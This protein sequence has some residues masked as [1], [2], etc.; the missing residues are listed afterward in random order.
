MVIKDAKKYNA[1][2]AVQKKNKIKRA[3][4]NEPVVIID[5]DALPTKTKG[6]KKK[7]SVEENNSYLKKKKKKKLDCKLNNAACI[8]FPIIMQSN[9]DSESIKETE[10]QPKVLKKKRKRRL[11]CEQESIPSQGQ[12]TESQEV[13]VLAGKKRKRH[14]PDTCGGD[15]E[16]NTKRKKKK[17]HKLAC[18]LILSQAEDDYSETDLSAT[19]KT[20]SHEMRL[21]DRKRTLVQNAVS[22]GQSRIIC[23]IISVDHRGTSSRILKKGTADPICELQEENYCKQDQKDIARMLKK[24]REVAEP[25]KK[26]SKKKLKK[27]EVDFLLTSVGNQE[28]H[29]VSTHTLWK[30]KSEEK[31][32]KTNQIQNSKEDRKGLKKKKIYAKVANNCSDLLEGNKD[33]FDWEEKAAI[34]R[35]K[36]KTKKSKKERDQAARLENCSFQENSGK[37]HNTKRKAEKSKGSKEHEE[38]PISKQA[39]IKKEAKEREDEIQVVA[40]KK[41][42]CDEI[43]IDK[44]RRQALQEEIDRESGKTKAVK[45][46]D[47]L[48]HHF[49]QW[50]TATFDST[51]RKTK[52]LRL[53]GGFKKGPALTQELPT[54]VMKHNMALARHGEEKLQRSLQ[55]QFEKASDWKQ[56]RGAGLGFQSA[57]QKHTYIDKYASKSIKLKD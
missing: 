55:A 24:R 18:S 15:S 44:S 56:Q 19:V 34:K 38:E 2:G 12:S 49:G 26:K 39:K 22:K 47:E 9:S 35:A 36:K 32:E 50:S 33:V 16:Y 21:S 31:Q 41:G 1:E 6:K 27:E 37:Q 13:C 3:T 40:I 8:D 45:E 14:V 57:P 10:K 29:P 20:I 7:R 51:E 46:E 28:N 30:T 43:R 17:K 23:S 48:D 52:F 54:N 25:K 11:Y 42:N 5:D 4:S 53:L